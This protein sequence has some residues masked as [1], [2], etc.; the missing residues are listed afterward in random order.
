MSFADELAA[1]AQPKPGKID[2]ILEAMDPDDAEAFRSAMLDPTI[3]ASRI[4]KALNRFDGIEETISD[5]PVR[6]WRERHSPKP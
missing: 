6:Q 5:K 3:P 1:L 4:V 2:Q